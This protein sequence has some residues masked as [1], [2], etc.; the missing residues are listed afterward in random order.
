MQQVGGLHWAGCQ[1]CEVEPRALTAISLARGRVAELVGAGEVLKGERD[2]LL[3]L[4]Q[5]GAG[6][7]G[8]AKGAWGEA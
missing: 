8:A 4:I 1:E 2:A 5:V 3:Q 7:A 6:A